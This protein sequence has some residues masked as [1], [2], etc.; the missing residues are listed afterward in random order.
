MTERTPRERMVYAAVQ[1]IRERGVTDTGMRDVVARAEA[2]RGSLQHYF[3]GGKR[4][5]VTEALEWSAGFAAS[6]VTKAVAAL[7][8][9]T[10]GALFALMT[11]RW[12]DELL[13]RDFLRGCPLVASAADVGASDPQLGAT[14]RQSFDGWIEATGDALQ[15]LG[16]EASRARSLA[17]VM[18]SALEGA[19]VLARARRDVAPLD[20][21]TRELR[22]LLDGAAA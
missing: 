7:T 6:S 21:V 12:R 10:P 4:Q 14:I 18:I 22:P 3:P 8:E 13:A 2:P 16:V 17:T 11:R 19:I 9:P 1:S 5:L 20:D 15:Q